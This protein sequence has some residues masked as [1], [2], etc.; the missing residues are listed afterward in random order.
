MDTGYLHILHTPLPDVK[1]TALVTRTPFVE[2]IIIKHF[3][4]QKMLW[5]L[6]WTLSFYL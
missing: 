2:E 4:Q 3:S 6:A 5:I 1:V